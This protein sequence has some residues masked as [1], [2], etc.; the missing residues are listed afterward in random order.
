M[1]DLQSVSHNFPSGIARNP[2]GCLP[3]DSFNLFCCDSV[4]STFWMAYLTKI[5]IDVFEIM[6]ESELVRDWFGTV[7]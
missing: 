7:L 2:P 1:N 4:R 6:F 3:A 5:G